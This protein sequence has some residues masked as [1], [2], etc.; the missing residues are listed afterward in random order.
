MRWIFVSGE[1]QTMEMVG[2]THLWM[3]GEKVVWKGYIEER[4]RIKQ[5]ESNRKKSANDKKKQAT[6]ILTNEQKKYEKKREWG[7][8]DK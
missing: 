6:E 4:Q 3:K 5:V 2:E 1:G 7:K 8:H